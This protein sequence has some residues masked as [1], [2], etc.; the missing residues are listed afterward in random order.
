MTNYDKVITLPIRELAGLFEMFSGHSCGCDNC[1]VN[2]R[3][4]HYEE[5]NGEPKYH[6]YITSENC[7]GFYKWLKE[8]YDQKLFDASLKRMEEHGPFEDGEHFPTGWRI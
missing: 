4:E 7:D 8:P 3:C 5:Y 1:L 6:E 2:D